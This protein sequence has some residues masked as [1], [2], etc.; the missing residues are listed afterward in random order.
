M[1]YL[2]DQFGNISQLPQILKDF[3]IG[4]VVFG[5]GYSFYDEEGRRLPTKS[6]FLWRGPDGTEALA[7][8]MKFWYNNAQRFSAKIQ[9]A[10]GLLELVNKQ[11]QDV[12]LTP[13]LLLMNGVDHLEAQDDLL[14]I[15]EQVQ[16]S[17]PRGKRSA[18]CAWTT[19]SPR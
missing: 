19:T 1:G 12:A 17:C 14:P 18:R 15:L 7:V 9:N 4:S 2:P 5:R 6:E 3:G 11:F 8:H 10:L 16:K 13:Y